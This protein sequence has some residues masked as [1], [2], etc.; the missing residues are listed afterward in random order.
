M[1]IL[2]QKRFEG[3]YDSLKTGALTIIKKYMDLLM[4]SD[5]FG[6][7]RVFLSLLRGT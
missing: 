4:A 2:F 6:I 3:L 1:P 5:Y 7:K